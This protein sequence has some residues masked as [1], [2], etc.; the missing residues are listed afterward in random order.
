MQYRTLG[1]TGLAVSVAALGAGGASRLGSARGVARSESIALVHE[2]LDLGVNLVDTAPTYGTEE[3][4][5]D[6]LAG[7]RE[8]VI[9]ST[10]AR[11]NRP[12]TP[13][14]STDYVTAAEF[15]ESVENSL[16]CLRTDRIDLLHVHGVRPHQYDYCVRVLLP[17]MQKLRRAGK[18]RFFGMTEGFGV[19]AEHD[20]L[21]RAIADGDW[22]VTMGGFNILN[23]SAALRVLPDCAAHDVGFLCMYAVRG[24]LTNME[25]LEAAI[26]RMR[27]R[28][29]L[30]DDGR[31]VAFLAAVR[32]PETTLSEM[33]YRFCRHTDGVSAVLFGTG[34]R[35]HLRQNIEWMNQ[36]PLTPDF[37]ECVR[38][39]FAR[40]RRETGDI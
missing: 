9:L 1:R 36:P 34:D 5:G 17:E 26:V 24:A 6:A 12:G 27:E 31:E 4:V 23:P 3:L 25:R 7:H 29:E 38:N 40:V 10:K 2:A 28:G 32:T 39:V 16:R 21:R 8:R 14:D 20:V 22:D 11:A 30:A 35:R 37:I 13:L 15:A 18:V 19:D 33:A